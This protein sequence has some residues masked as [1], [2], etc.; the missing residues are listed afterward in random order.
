MNSWSQGPTFLQQLEML[1]N[2]D[3]KFMDPNGPDF[4]HTLVETTKL[5]FADREKF[6]GD[7]KFVDVPMDILLSKEYGRQRAELVQAGIK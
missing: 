7:P 1:K 5:A 4:V 2:L 6:Y 3:V